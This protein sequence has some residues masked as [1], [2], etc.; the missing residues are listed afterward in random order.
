MQIYYHLLNIMMYIMYL[1]HY[2]L[3]GSCKC[4][5]NDVNFATQHQELMFLSA[6]TS[7]PGS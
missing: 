2:S 3:E 5:L 7:M 6:F 1:S 4:S